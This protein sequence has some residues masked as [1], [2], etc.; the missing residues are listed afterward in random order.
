MYIVHFVMLV[1]VVGLLVLSL[2]LKFTE[3]IVMS[4]SLMLCCI[5]MTLWAADLITHMMG[6]GFHF[7]DIVFAC[8]ICFALLLMGIA[9]DHAYRRE[10]ERDAEAERSSRQFGLKNA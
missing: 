4:S 1:A 2:I 8:V 7:E 3:L 9:G 5:A 10:E 6:K